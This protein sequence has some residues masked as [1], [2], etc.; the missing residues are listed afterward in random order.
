MIAR[1]RAPRLRSPTCLAGCALLAA[2][3]CGNHDQDAG[4]SST[5]PARTAS[6]LSA[7][8]LSTA[9]RTAE[10]ASGAR[11]RPGGPYAGWVIADP[12]QRHA[13]ATESIFAAPSGPYVAQTAGPNEPARAFAPVP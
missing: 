9:T 5:P 7:R 4:S 13:V 6:T 12:P 11:Q 1:N 10:V 8:T 3:A 2:I